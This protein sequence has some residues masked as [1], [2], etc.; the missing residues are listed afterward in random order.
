MTPNFLWKIIYKVYPPLLRFLEKTKF[1]KGRQPYRLGTLNKK[2]T[3]KD[4]EKFL[5]SKG[6]EDVVL[7]WK[8]TGEI[9]GMRKIDKQIFQYH[10]RLFDDGEI[11][12]HYEYSSEG[13]PWNHCVEKVF[14][15][16]EKHFKKLLGKFLIFS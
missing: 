9:L 7:T 16:R 12:G 14:E 5:I 8:D 13:S 6:F 11:R 4:L 3:K 1:H 2:Y 15:R 10:I